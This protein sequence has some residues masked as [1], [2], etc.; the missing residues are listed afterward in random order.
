MFLDHSKFVGILPVAVKALQRCLD[1][2]IANQPTSQNLYF[3]NY[4]CVQNN[5]KKKSK[6]Q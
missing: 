1:H 3:V 4:Q 2:I 5:L 6:Q